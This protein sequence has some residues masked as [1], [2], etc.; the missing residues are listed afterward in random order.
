MPASLHAGWPCHL[1]LDCSRASNILR[2]VP[3]CSDANAANCVLMEIEDPQTN[4][5]HIFA[6]SYKPLRNHTALVLLTSEP[7][8]PLLH[9]GA[10]ES[11]ALLEGGA[12]PSH[13]P[14]VINSP[15]E[16]HQRQQQILF[17][18]PDGAERMNTDPDQPEQRQDGTLAAQWSLTSPRDPRLNNLPPPHSSAPAQPWIW[19]HH[20]LGPPLS[21]DPSS[22]AVLPA[23]I[24]PAINAALHENGLPAPGT[25]H[26]ETPL[27]GLG[28]QA[29]PADNVLQ[30]SSDVGAP[31]PDSLPV[32]R[33]SMQ[34][35]GESLLD[36]AAE[37]DAWQKLVHTKLKAAL[38]RSTEEA[39]EQGNADLQDVSCA[40]EAR[41]R[42]D[43]RQQDLR[44]VA[45]YARGLKKI[46][47]MLDHNEPNDI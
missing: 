17:G 35:L 6:F 14:P 2:K 18:H 23:D 9:S 7:S 44:K 24:Q 32:L 29:S 20:P 41:S 33:Q 30:Q 12:Q 3:L 13:A 5:P 8:C 47:H 45:L 15:P 36:E 22:G 39:V 38:K 25:M 10:L 37:A 40:E 1:V 31:Q 4:C 19:N 16:P 27:A 21:R 43:R 11:P 34:T 26:A 42:V 28:M 46:V